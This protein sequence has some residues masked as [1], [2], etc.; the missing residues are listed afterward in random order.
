MMLICRAVLLLFAELLIEYSFGTMLTKFILKK[1]TSPCLNLLMGFAAYQ[2][3]FQAAALAVTLSTRIL[4]HLVFVWL[5]LLLI[6]VPLSFWYGRDRMKRQFK[7]AVSIAGKKQKTL[8]LLGLAVAAFCYYTSING[9][10]NDDACYYIGLMTT[11]VDTDT[12]FQYNA[13]TGLEME[14]LYLRRALA[15]FEI[16]SAVLSKMTG[17]HPL[18]IARIFRACQ[19][20]I[21][22]SAA[23]LLCS[24]ELF[25]KEDEAALEKSVFTTG[26]FWLLQ[27]PFAQ[28]IYTPAYFL[29]YRTYEAKAFTANLI[30]LFGLYLCV[31]ALREAE[32]RYFILI[33][34]YLWGSMALSASALVVALAECVLLLVP[35][36]LQRKIVKRKQERIHAD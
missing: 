29:L 23:V 10:M 19:N 5:L 2:A 7:T 18:I 24:R 17:I 15:T 35:I 1:E 28:T 36:R 16:H 22:T 34:I 26:I 11:T 4:H 9:E 13:Y 20:V 33:G 12:L 8:M 31:K 25:W 27:M 6:L 30:V 14:S 32:C 21:L 3:L